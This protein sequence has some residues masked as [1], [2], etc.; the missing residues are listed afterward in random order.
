MG[1]NYIF[2]NGFFF[3][4][5]HLY[6]REREKKENELFFLSLIAGKYFFFLT[7]HSVS[8]AFM[9]SCVH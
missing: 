8:L 7:F 3:L 4:Q 5:K 9:P 2:L 1:S 6:L